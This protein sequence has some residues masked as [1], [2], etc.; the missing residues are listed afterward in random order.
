MVSGGLVALGKPLKARIFLGA[1]KSPYRPAAIEDK[2]WS[3]ENCAGHRT[4]TKL[5][6]KIRFEECFL[7]A[8]SGSSNEE[9]KHILVWRLLR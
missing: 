5:M 2:L 4:S 7:T 9:K 3:K 8:L 6:H 1:Q